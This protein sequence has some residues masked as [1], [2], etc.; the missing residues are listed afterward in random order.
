MAIF[1]TVLFYAFAFVLSELLRPQAPDAKAVAFEDFGFPSVDPQ[2]RI[3][4]V[5]G[6][7]RIDSVHTVDVLNFYTLKIKQRTGLFSKTVVGYKYFVG[8]SVGIARSGTTL[9]RIFF[10][11]K[12]VWSGTAAPADNGVDIELLDEN[13]F[14][15][16][17]SG[18]GFGGTVTYYGGGST[19][20][21]D[22]YMSSYESPTP[23]YRHISMLVFKN[24]YWGNFGTMPRIDVEVERYPNTLGLGGAKTVVTDPG[25]P[26]ML[27]VAIPEIIHEVLTNDDWG[28]GESDVNDID[29]ASFSAAATT[30]ATEANGMSLKW[31]RGDNMETVIRTC[32]AQ[33]D[34]TL[35]KATT[36]GKWTLKLAR[37]DYLTSPL[38]V[39]Q[40]DENNCRLIR[41]NRGSWDQTFNEVHV[42][43]SRRDSREP[44]APAVEFD[45]AN[46]EIQ[47]VHE[48]ST[49]QHPG[50]YSESL[51]Q[52]LAA[53]SMTQLG[54][55]L[56]QLEILADRNAYNLNP[57]DVF[58]FAW[59]EYDI[60]RMFFRITKI[61]LGTQDIGQIRITAFQDV[62]GLGSTVFGNPQ[63]SLYTGLNTSSANAITVAHIIEQ[64]YFINLKDPDTTTPGA[65]HKVLIA[66][67]PPQANAVN[68]NIFY[69][70]S[71]APLLLEDVVG[72]FTPSGLLANALTG[73]ASPWDNP[74]SVTLNNASSLTGIGA[75]TDAE[76]RQAGF[77]LAMVAE[78][79]ASPK[80]EEFI[81]FES[82]VDNLDG[83]FTLTDVQRGLL[84][85]VPRDWGSGARVWLIGEFF[86]T[87]TQDSVS[88]EGFGTLDIRLFNVA[89][90][91]AT[92]SPYSTEVRFTNRVSLPLPPGN[93]RFQS[94]GA[95]SPAA[96]RFRD[97][98]LP[99]PAGNIA[100]TW[101]RRNRQASSIVYQQD[102]DAGAQ[103]GETMRVEIYSGD[104]SPTSPITRG[105]LL[106]TLEDTGTSVTYTTAQQIT[107]GNPSV[108]WVEAYKVGTSSPEVRSFRTIVRQIGLT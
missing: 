28:L 108:I 4:V 25:A 83:T 78:D 37:A 104:S 10:D 87:T 99:L 61:S 14:G 76:R 42:N 90:D 45:M 94:D 12:V 82:L 75:A 59:D 53:R 54:F 81:S 27:D 72:E 8:I 64:P 35:Y 23:A 31:M 18:G 92:L 63:V 49:V 44:P 57:G 55:P 19:Q 100:F 85:S 29:T 66:A 86:A 65:D 56:I 2:R 24:F 102:G 47:G 77:N 34:A 73:D 9:R 6:R 33:A 41:F 91:A 11:D 79:N 98:A 80:V 50:C 71:P 52:K 21:S 93:F 39:T 89:S 60:T 38:T 58:E 1:A 101:Q 46:F 103:G 22:D 74:A 26:D 106:R 68:Y 36:D 88:P 69:R 67:K 96:A 107:D 30:L 3:P 95:V 70:Q 15:G 51:A 20:N 105:A 97:P 48:I 13:F 5:F 62:F 43:W 32:L 84:D 16:D 7:V 17:R 40:F